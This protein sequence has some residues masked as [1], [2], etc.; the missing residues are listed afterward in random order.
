M[1]KIVFGMQKEILIGGIL[2]VPTRKL[3]RYVTDRVGNFME[4]E[5]YFPFWRS[6]SCTINYG[7]LALI[8]IEYDNESFDVPRIPKG[9]DGRAMG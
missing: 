4:L 8:A 7:L 2:I 6:L 1:N 3:Y 5:P 9:T